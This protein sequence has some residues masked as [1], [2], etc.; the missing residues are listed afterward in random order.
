MIISLEGLPGAGKTTLAMVIGT[1]LGAHIVR[2]T[3]ADHPFL[4]QVYDDRHRDDLTVELGFL[5]VHANP[6]RLLPRSQ[7]CLTDYS[8]VKDLLFAEDMLAGTELA[9]F[10]QSYNVLYTSHPRPEIAVYLRAAPDICLRRIQHRLTAE[11]QRSFETGVTLDRL[12]RMHRRYDEATDRLADHC[13]IYHVREGTSVKDTAAE[14]VALL[15]PH[16][17]APTAI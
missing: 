2:E 14:I 17:Q 16:L 4:A 13:L 7:L 15:N 12:E 9:F 3:T 1:Q 8:P 11:P 6:Y 10:R 5:I